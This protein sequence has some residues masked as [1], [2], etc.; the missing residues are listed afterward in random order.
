MVVL[1]Y[2][3]SV[4]IQILERNVFCSFYLITAFFHIVKAGVFHTYVINVLIVVESDD[5]DT[6]LTLFAG[7]IFEV[8][9]A[10]GRSIAT[11]T[12][13]TVFVLQIDAEYGFA[14][15]ADSDVTNTFSISPP[16]QV[17][18]LMRITRSKSGLSM[19]QFS[20]NRLR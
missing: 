12:L 13:F 2:K 14:T 9:V 19:R 11:V 15:L 16:R 20:T 8:Y 3:F 6:E 18:V 10:Y 1:L 5:E 7:Y 4:Y 17:L